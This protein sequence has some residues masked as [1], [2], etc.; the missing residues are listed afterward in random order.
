MSQTHLDQ[1][2]CKRKFLLTRGSGRVVGVTDPGGVLFK[3]VD[4]HL[5]VRVVLKTRVVAPQREKFVCP[6]LFLV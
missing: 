4:P 1:F 5:P 2:C 3:A 6:H